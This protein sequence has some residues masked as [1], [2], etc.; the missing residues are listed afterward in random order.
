[1]TG[2]TDDIQGR[3]VTRQGRAQFVQLL[4]QLLHDFLLQRFVPRRGTDIDQVEHGGDLGDV[5]VRADRLRHACQHQRFSW[6]QQG[7]IGF[8][9]IRTRHIVDKDPLLGNGP[10]G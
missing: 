6:L 5:N 1:M 2:G 10:P 4:L 7:T 3:D 8:V 9:Q